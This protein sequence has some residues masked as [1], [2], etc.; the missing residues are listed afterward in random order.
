MV[1]S[2]RRT[3]GRNKQAP[4]AR[5]PD[6]GLSVLRLALDTHDPVQRARIEAMF[7]GAYRVQ[8]ALDANQHVRQ[9]R[10]LVVLAGH[11]LAREIER[12]GI[13]AHGERAP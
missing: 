1:S 11:I 7:R 8:R 13:E 2:G 6:E 10:F 4:W 3:R 12:R 5:R 9:V